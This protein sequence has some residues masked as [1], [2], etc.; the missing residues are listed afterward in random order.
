MGGDFGKQYTDRNTLSLEEMEALYQRNYGMSRTE[1]NE[2]FLADLDRSIKI[3]EVG[4][5][6]GNQLLCLQRMGF[7]DIWG[8]ELQSYAVEISK[9]RTKDINII[10]ASAFDIPYKDF[11]F[12]MVFTSGLLI[13]IAPSD[14]G[15]LMEEI[16]RC[17]SEY[18]WGA[19]YYADQYTEID[20]REE[21]NLLW[22]A[23]FAT[24]YLN[25][26]KDLAL[27]KEKRIKYLDNANVNSMFLIRKR[28]A[29]NDE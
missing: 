29:K 7:S 1:L 27:I 25:R 18:I 2:L 13:H 24:L 16:Y 17:T 5:N 12:D 8:I 19:E 23:D 14:I 9:A 3:L 21:S 6:I 4:S 20:Y 10:K 26:F 15:I 28:S 11:Y 22:K